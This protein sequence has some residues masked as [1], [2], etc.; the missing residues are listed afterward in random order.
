MNIQA[1]KL[2]LIEWLIQLKD[3]AIINKIDTFRKKVSSYDPAKGITIEE[4]Y[5]ELAKAETEYK[6]GRITGIE[7]LEKESENW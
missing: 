1:K 3:E 5:A 2:G 4:L 7:D 6:E